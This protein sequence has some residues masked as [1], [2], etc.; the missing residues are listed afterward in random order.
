MISR[1]RKLEDGRLIPLNFFRVAHVVGFG[2][3]VCHW[4]VTSALE[5]STTRRRKNRPAVGLEVRKATRDILRGLDS[6]NIYAYSAR[7]N[8]YPDVTLFTFISRYISLLQ[9]YCYYLSFY[10][11]MSCG[12]FV[13][14]SL[15]K[16]M[17]LID[18]KDCRN[19]ICIITCYIFRNDERT[20]LTIISLQS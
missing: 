14:D 18:N 3:A 7:G 10:I 13:Y 16:R 5:A 12:Y 9:N 8:E 1:A 4:Y 2:H 11:I 19:L 20:K 6:T 17:R 15:V